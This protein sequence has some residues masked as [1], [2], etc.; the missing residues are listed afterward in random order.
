MK[1]EQ[2]LG[3]LLRWRLAQ[4]EAGAP[5][6]PRA[7]RL[8]ELARPWWEKWP[9]KFEALAAQLNATQSAYGH[10]MTV[11]GREREGYPVPVVI[12]MTPADHPASARILF[13]SIRDGR[14]RLRFELNTGVKIGLT[15]FDATFLDG[16][17]AAPLLEAPAIRSVDNEYRL[18]AELPAGLRTAW[19]ELRV[20]DR[21]P[22]RLILRAVPG[23][24][25]PGIE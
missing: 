11:S 3:Q 13:L 24:A 5:P 1:T 14:L 20:T 15:T 25:K 16:A 6:A 9:A 7:A 21:M 23:E 22:F 19:A 18:E 2:S 4:A 17:K 10:A 12:A 8:L